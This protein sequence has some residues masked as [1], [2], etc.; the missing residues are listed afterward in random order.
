ML[1]QQTPSL[2]GGEGPPEELSPQNCVLRAPRSWKCWNLTPRGACIGTKEGSSPSPGCSCPLSPH[3]S[4]SQ[5]AAA[6]QPCPVIT[7]SR[8]REGERG[9]PSLPLQQLRRTPAIPGQQCCGSPSLPMPDFHFCP[10]CRHASVP[11]VW[12]AQSVLITPLT[13]AAELLVSITARR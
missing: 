9:S 6:S 2:G 3:Q 13:Y 4:I 12:F 5:V 1:G 7:N 8:W 11:G 10:S